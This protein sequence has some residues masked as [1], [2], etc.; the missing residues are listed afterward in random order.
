[1]Y[2]MHQYIDVM[3]CMIYVLHPFIVCM[4]FMYV[5]MCVCGC[6]SY[7]VFHCRGMNIALGVNNKQLFKDCATILEGMKV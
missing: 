1:M 4:V 6:V 5:C 7:T 2:F 3:A